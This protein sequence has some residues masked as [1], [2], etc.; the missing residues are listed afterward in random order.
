MVPEKFG[1]FMQ[2]HETGLMPCTK[3]K[4]LLKWVIHQNIGAITM[5]VLVENQKITP[6][7][8]GLGK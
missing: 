5:K 7:D 6:D 3:D 1:L 8:L 4:N 2:N